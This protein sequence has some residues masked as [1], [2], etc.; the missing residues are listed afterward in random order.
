MIPISLPDFELLHNAAEGS[1]Q[2]QTVAWSSLL[3]EW[4]I[5]LQMEEL[6]VTDSGYSGTAGMFFNHKN[7]KMCLQH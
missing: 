3:T 7:V 1:K 6:V 2:K 4:Y 5:L